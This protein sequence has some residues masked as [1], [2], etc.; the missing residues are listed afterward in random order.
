M[1]A[2]TTTYGG[3]NMSM[4]AMFITV[5]VIV[6]MFFALRKRESGSAQGQSAQRPKS[7]GSDE[8]FH[9][10]SIRF[11]QSS[12]AAA[13]GMDG[14]RFLSS[15]APRLPL[16]DCDVLECK[17]KFVHH[18]DR[19]DGEDRR[20]PIRGGVAGGTTGEQEKEQ[21]GYRDRREDP[22]DNF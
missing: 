17:C 2:R 9:A 4:T 19:R 11:V 6:V 15:A 3:A 14:K 7:S 16:P 20:S 8:T 10:V 12:C 5:I 18:K 21:R 1:Y 13:K 22:P